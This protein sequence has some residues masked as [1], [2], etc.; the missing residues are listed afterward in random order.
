[1][2]ADWLQGTC[3]VSIRKVEQLLW[4][5]KEAPRTAETHIGG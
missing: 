3:E 1:M 5:R 4:M 2:S